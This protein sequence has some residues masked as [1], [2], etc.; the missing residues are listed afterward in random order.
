MF[1]KIV[2]TPKS[3][4]LIGVS[5]IFTIH[6]GV[7]YPYFWKHPDTSSSFPGRIRFPPPGG[8]K[9]QAKAEGTRAAE[10]GCLE[11]SCNPRVELALE[12]NNDAPIF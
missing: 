2:G 1:P 11:W 6:F 3:S 10:F 9:T 8:G 4:I 7:Q 5:I 12:K